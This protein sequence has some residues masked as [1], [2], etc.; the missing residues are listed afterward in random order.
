[1]LVLGGFGLVLFMVWANE[2]F[3]LPHL[4]FHAPPTP[5]NAVESLLETILI[6]PVAALTHVLLGRLTRKL[7]MLEGYIKVCASCRKVWD[8]Q[9]GWISWDHYVSLHSEARTTHGLCPECAVKLY[10]E[11]RL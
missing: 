7:Q 5:V 1:M 9:L 2:I 8:D 6:L 3:D 10:P 4:I 11:V